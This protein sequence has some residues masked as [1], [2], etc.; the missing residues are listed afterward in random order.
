MLCPLPTTFDRDFYSD[1]LMQIG[2][3]DS[4]L[5]VTHLLFSR[6]IDLEWGP[7]TSNGHHMHDKE[8]SQLAAKCVLECEEIQTH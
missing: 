1:L 7:K 3:V 8:L 5:L 6:H 4:R 2:A